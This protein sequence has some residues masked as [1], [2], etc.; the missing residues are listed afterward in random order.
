MGIDNCR[1]AYGVCTEGTS[2]CEKKKGESLHMIKS[3][4]GFI[5]GY[6]NQMNRGTPDQSQNRILRE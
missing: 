6:H 4:F 3:G 5:K 2:K 1:K